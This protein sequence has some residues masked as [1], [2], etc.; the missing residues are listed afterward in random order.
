MISFM[1]DM[2]VERFIQCYKGSKGTG[3]SLALNMNRRFELCVW[4]SCRPSSSSLKICQSLASMCGIMCDQ[5]SQRTYNVLKIRYTCKYVQCVLDTVV[6]NLSCKQALAIF[7]PSYLH[8][9]RRY[10]ILYFYHSSRCN[11]I[12]D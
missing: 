8:W 1:L 12:I 9:R 10:N 7:S 6:C 5:I 4:W 11:I 2:I 3:V